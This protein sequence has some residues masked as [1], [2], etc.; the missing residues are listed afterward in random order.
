MK[1][2][3]NYEGKREYESVFIK[4]PRHFASIPSIRQLVLNFL[5]LLIFIKK[6]MPLPPHTALST[7][8]KFINELY[9]RRIY[10]K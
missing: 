10:C 1:V 3:I 2:G 5:L 4:C 6:I 9:T 7:F 8:L